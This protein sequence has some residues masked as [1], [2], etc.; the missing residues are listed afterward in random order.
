MG[1][2]PRFLGPLLNHT[3]PPFLIHCSHPDTSDLP[4]LPHMMCMVP[5]LQLPA[6]MHFFPSAWNSLCPRVRQANT[7]LLFNRVTHY[8][9]SEACLNSLLQN[10]G[11]RTCACKTPPAYLYFSSHCSATRCF[12]TCQRSLGSELLTY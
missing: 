4:A 6:S 1:F 12:S 3:S 8:L 5:L 11:Y 10:C 2:P 7:C 9:F